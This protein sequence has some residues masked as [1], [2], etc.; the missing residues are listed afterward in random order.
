MI[1]NLKCT[2]HLKLKLHACVHQYTFIGMIA[3][4]HDFLMF[5]DKILKVHAYTQPHTHT[6]THTHVHKKY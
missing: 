2:T 3:F 1:N 6:H 5:F 4:L